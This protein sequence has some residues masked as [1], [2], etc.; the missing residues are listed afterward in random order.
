MREHD[1]G[2][3]VAVGCGLV[4]EPAAR[5]APV[6]KPVTPMLPPK[7]R[8]ATGSN[9][10]GICACSVSS[11]SNGA[12]TG[13]PISPVMIAIPDSWSDARAI[14]AAAPAPSDRTAR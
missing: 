1:V 9:R 7:N 3:Q 14:G 10:T 13:S 11:S 2:Q 5:S 4:S 6:S 8:F 12:S